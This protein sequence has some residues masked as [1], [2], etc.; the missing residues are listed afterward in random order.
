MLK[1]VHDTFLVEPETSGDYY[2]RFWT[3]PNLITSF[4]ILI[5]CIN[6]GL[7]YYGFA[8]IFLFSVVCLVGDVI[9]GMTDLA[10]GR[11]ARKLKQ[12]SWWGER[13]DPARDMM[14]VVN[15]TCHYAT[16][17]GYSAL[18]GWPIWIALFFEA[19]I[20]LGGWAIG[21]SYQVSSHA[22]GKFRRAGQV[23]IFFFLVLFETF[24]VRTIDSLDY[25]LPI[26][27]VSS[28]IAF[29][30]YMH[31]NRDRL[32]PSLCNLLSLLAQGMSA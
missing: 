30:S 8:V 29:T 24:G 17:V 7:I 10:D 31:A 25:L 19:L 14:I 5:G 4:G 13:L 3:V 22:V 18:N 27:A 12:R 23:G 1:T 32:I 2:D 6:F 15:L 16:Y 21:R 9:M 28:V 20:C 11:Y 26:V